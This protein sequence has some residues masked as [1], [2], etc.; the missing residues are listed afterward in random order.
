MKL[1]RILLIACLLCTLT[2][3]ADAQRRN[4]RSRTAFA[5]EATQ[6][7]VKYITKSNGKQVPGEPLQL[8]IHH[9]QAFILP[10]NNT[11]QKEQQYLDYNKKVSYQV[12]TRANG[13]TFTL[14][15]PFDSYVKG[16]L[17][18]D[19]AHILGFVCKKAKFMIRSNTIEVWYTTE[20]V[21]KGTPNITVGADLGLVL[22]IV[23]N[24]NYETIATGFEKMQQDQINWPKQFGQMVDEPAYMQQV[25]ESRYNTI[26]IFKEDQISWGNETPNP[27]GDQL[28]VTY[29]FAGGTVIAKKVHLPT[30]QPGSNLFATLTQ[31]SN[32]DAYDRTGSLF[33]IP[34]DK[35]T[36]FLD[37]L[38][39]GIKQ[40]PAITGTNGKTYQGMV[41][42][43]NY[44]PVLELM[45]FFTPFGVKHFNNQV[46]IKGYNWADSAVYKQDITPLASSLSGDV[47][48]AVYIGNYDKGGH[49]VSLDFNYYPGFEEEK[50][51]RKPWIMPI[52]NT[53]NV[54]EMA[55]QEYCTLFDKDSLTVTVNVPAGLKNVQLRY[56]ATGHGGWGGGDE[57]NPKQ[58]E[59]FLD[60]KR[61]YNFVPWR[62]DCGTYRMLNPASGN[63]GNGL[64]SSDLSRSNWCP[65]TLTQPVNIYLYDLQPGV[66]TFKV[67]IPQGKPEGGSFSF[68]NVS[69]VLI[70]EKES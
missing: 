58:H 67:A 41:A 45:R 22:K 52:F 6:L 31:Y 14:E 63:F 34:V 21:A 20:T 55:G 47:W 30:L 54:M 16:E 32:G 18:K 12:L 25:I 46:K 40:V 65:G 7:T 10:P 13:Q 62:E 49:K 4:T 61:V 60:G 59:I 66:H 42:T 38:K 48:L 26:N 39:N 68:W 53:T 23:R 33:M 19:T 11:P 15:K 27:Q 17:L 51:T 69:G 5:K 43:D 3:A 36:S 37:A 50:T 8:I 9:Q 56:T 28:N 35:N 70:G 2:Y 64:S 57:F 24:G 1:R 44:T 29:H